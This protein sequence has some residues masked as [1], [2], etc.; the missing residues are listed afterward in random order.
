[1]MESYRLSGAVEAAEDALGEMDDHLDDIEEILGDRLS[2]DVTADVDAMRETLE[3]LADDLDDASDGA[4]AWR[5]IE[6][7]GAM[8]TADALFQIDRSWD[9]VP[10]VI[11]RINGLIGDFGNLMGRLYAPAA[12]P[13]GPTAVSVP[14]RGG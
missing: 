7:S 8:P 14:A 12:M 9:E 1:M 2:D 4:G 13:E 10:G 5:G 6:G 3:E 11:D